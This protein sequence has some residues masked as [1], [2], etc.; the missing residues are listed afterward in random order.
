K[1]M[2]FFNDMMEPEQ[3]VIWGKAFEEYSDLTPEFKAMALVM[4][5]DAV[6]AK[7]EQ[8]IDA[9]DEELEAMLARLIQ[10]REQLLDYIARECPLDEAEAYKSRKSDVSLNE[11]HM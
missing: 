3:N 5:E 10:E 2:K 1:V 6:D 11:M 7:V 8:V 4:F 9:M